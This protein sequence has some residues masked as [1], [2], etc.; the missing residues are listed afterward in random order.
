MEG[1]KPTSVSLYY[2]ESCNITANKDSS[3]IALI[4]PQS[5]ATAVSYEETKLA[6]TGHS[7]RSY[8]VSHYSQKPLV[9][10]EKEIKDLPVTGNFGT[11]VKGHISTPAFNKQL[12]SYEKR[13]MHDHVDEI[14]EARNKKGKKRDPKGDPTSMDYQGP[15]AKF[16]IEHLEFQPP[17]VTDRKIE[18]KE[19]ESNTNVAQLSSLGGFPHT[20]PSD[21]EALCEVNGK[22]TKFRN[23]VVSTLHCKISDHKGKSWN[24]GP[25]GLK[26]RDE[27]IYRASMPKNEIFTYNG[28]TMGVQC[29]RFHPLTGHLLLS[30]ALDGYLKIW[31]VFNAR[32]C[33][34][35]FKG[36]GKGIRQAE[37]NCMG[38]KFFSCSFDENTIMWDVEYGKICGVYI[39]GNIPYC[40]TPHPKDP[41]IFLVGGSNKKVIQYDARTGKI[42]VEYAEHLGTVNTISFFENDRKLITSGDDKKILL[43]EFGL[44]V[45][46]KHIN[47]PALHSI[48]AAA[49]HPKTDFILL[50]SM[51]NQLLTFDVDS[52][53]LSRKTFRGHV[54]KG[55]AIKP[56]TSPDGKFVVSGDSRGHT[57]IWDWESTKCLTTLKGHSTVV[58]DVA[59]HP[60]MPARLATASWDSTIK[61]YD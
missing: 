25:P 16:H 18:I 4:R 33:L 3:D 43:W 45:V 2:Q 60:T 9:E 19:N 47:D 48:P 44:P 1:A 13:N 27:S 59:W 38:D 53:S 50:Q 11:T 30:G 34:R 41:N 20:F 56:T 26:L 21:A 31:D 42:E 55:Y 10:P 23:R 15:W 17:P 52:F 57:Y 7:I 5:L 32:S 49:K 29:I 40:V 58:I 37:F 12:Y 39:T 6:T 51:D 54:S 35:T 36:H 22:Q 46:I 8:P 14:K 61:I 24:S 28:H